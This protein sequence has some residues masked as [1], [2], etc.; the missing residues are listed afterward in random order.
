MVVDLGLGEA[1]NGH[2]R[3]VSQYNV[4]SDHRAV[5]ICVGGVIKVYFSSLSSISRSVYCK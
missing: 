5:L 2:L 4:P 1:C 3:T